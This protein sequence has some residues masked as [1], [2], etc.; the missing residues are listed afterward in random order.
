[1]WFLD[2]SILKERILKEDD[3]ENGK[4]ESENGNYRTSWGYG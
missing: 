4:S 1:V 2:A 3:F